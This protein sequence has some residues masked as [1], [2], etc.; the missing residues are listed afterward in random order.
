MAKVAINGFGRVGRQVF[1]RLIDSFPNIEIVAVNDLFPADQLAFLAVHDSNYGT[2]DKEIKVEENAMVVGGKTVKVFAEKDPSNLPWKELGVDIVIESSGVFTAKEKAMAHINAGAKKVIIT[3]SATNE[4]IT[5]VIGVNEKLLDVERHVVISN[6]TCTTNSIAPVIKVIN[7][8]I[9]IEKGYLV[10]THSYTQD[11]RLLDSPH[12]DPRRARSAATNIIPTTTGAAKAVALTI[13]ELKGKLD[14]MSLRVPTPTVSISVFEAY[15]KR[16]STVEE[17]N[18]FLKEASETY[19]KGILGY[20]E[21]PL[22]S[23]DFKGTTFSGVV[24]AL[25]TKVVDG[26]FLN[27]VSWYDNE[28]GYSC[29]VADLTDLISKKAGY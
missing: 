2:W 16:N 6:A 27:V 11:Q 17:V 28:W 19:M 25:T 9:G 24:D 10:T 14:G 3:A 18:A 5:V 13:P 29:R 20:T 26:N 21:E 1:K 4:D 23:S 8:K 12:K 7:D 15:L 22:V